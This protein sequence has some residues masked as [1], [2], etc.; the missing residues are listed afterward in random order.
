VHLVGFHYKTISRCTVL[1]MS[2]LPNLRRNRLLI[3]SYF[4]IV[5]LF[6]LYI[7]IYIYEWAYVVFCYLTADRKNVKFAVWQAEN[8]T[9]IIKMTVM[10]R[11]TGSSFFRLGYPCSR[12]S[13]GRDVTHIILGKSVFSHVLI[14]CLQYLTLG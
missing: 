11:D 14:T 13:Q 2:N 5:I 6:L 8:T 1:W 12:V 3:F 4:L 10:I 9:D 7:Y